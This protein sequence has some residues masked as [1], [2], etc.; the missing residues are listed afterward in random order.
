MV[1]FFLGKDRPPSLLHRR[2]EGLGMDR[3]TTTT[4]TKAAITKHFPLPP[5]AIRIRSP[6][7]ALSRLSSTRSN[8]L[9]PSPPP[10]PCPPPPSAVRS[11]PQQSPSQSKLQS[12]FTSHNCSLLRHME[13]AA[14]SLYKAKLIYAFCHLYDGQEAVCV[15]RYAD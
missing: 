5:S 12:L 6:I 11:Q 7:M 10:Q 13:I 2:T 15:G 14:D 1:F 8:L 4:S 3:W 9:R